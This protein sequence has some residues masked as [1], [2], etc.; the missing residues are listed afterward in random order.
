MGSR[1]SRLVWAVWIVAMLCYVVA[2]VN[3]SSLSA[4][5]PVAQQH[6]GIDATMLSVFMVIQLLVYACC[7]IPVGILLD[8]FGAT[9]MILAG[10][11]L[12]AVGQSLMATVDGLWLAIAARVLVGAG[13]ACTFICVI[14]MLGEWFPVRQLPVVTQVTGL[15]G[16]TG[17]LVS[18]VPL[19]LAVGAFGW[20]GGMLGLVAVG[21]LIG[22]LG[23]VVLRDHP[24]GGTVVDRL[25]GRPGRPERNA[26]S[27]LSVTSVL[28]DSV[29]VVTGSILLPGS[30]GEPRGRAP[31]LGLLRRPGIRLA[32]W[33][34]FTT[35]FAM[36]T[37]L[38]LW[39]TPFLVGGMGLSS[40]ASAGVL[41]YTVV[42]S[43]SAGLLLGPLTARFAAQ[44]VWVAIGMSSLIVAAWSWVLLS[45]GAAPLWLIFVLATVI[46]VGGPTSM[47][48]FEVLR[49][50]VP[51]ERLGLGT[52]LVNTGGFTSALLV[53]LGIGLILDML[54]A[55][56]PDS[57]ST[58][59]FKIAM[60]WQLPF[61][62]LGLVMMLV[63]FPRAK[64][65]LQAR[66]GRL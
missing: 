16:Q 2:I 46:G 59:A 57:Y 3:R 21:V 34:H 26:Q 20:M 15:V 10:A 1:R 63:E 14:R 27:P 48:S 5:G 6:F 41:S 23:L 39:G 42:V 50:H 37:F 60:A 40:E 64:R 35:P 31:L 18:V 45:P 32:Y 44:R 51:P 52:G 55:G 13:D 24:G 28:T 53:I 38:L 61:L 43:M 36:H 47:I 25:R 65:A 66:G 62:L 11:L 29:P 58:G 8:R 12:M 22:I 4:L 30:E 9:A 56:S 7:Q 19:S 54:G 33:V 17:Q 49:T